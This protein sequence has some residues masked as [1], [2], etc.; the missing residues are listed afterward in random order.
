[1]GAAVLFSYQALWSFP[2]LMQGAWEAARR[3]VEIAEDLDL[4][5]APGERV[6][7]AWAGS[8]FYFSGVA[9]V[10]LLGKCDPVVAGSPADAALGGTGHNKLD[11]AESLGRRRPAWVLLVPP[12]SP[13]PGGWAHTPFDA[14]IWNDPLFTA[15]CRGRIL[16]VGGP[17]ALCRCD[18]PPL[19]S[20]P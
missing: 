8:F 4:R 18:W 9:G 16:P 3:R 13:D 19:P 17:W 12:G 5:V 20:H 7:A 11:L 15:H 1:M 14:R 6:A 10:D 2:G